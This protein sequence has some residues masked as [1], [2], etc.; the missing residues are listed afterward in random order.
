MQKING[1]WGMSMP[2]TSLNT[3]ALSYV[4]PSASKALK[5]KI[6]LRPFVS[7]TNVGAPI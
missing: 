7:F 6:L 3:F 1:K 2:V 4:R 5:R